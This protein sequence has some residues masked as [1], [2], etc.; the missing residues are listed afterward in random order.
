VVE[1]VLLMSEEDSWVEVKRVNRTVFETAIAFPGSHQVIVEGI[2]RN[3]ERIGK[4][5]NIGSG[6]ACE[7][8]PR[9]WFQNP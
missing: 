3:G 9:F 1:W 4:S 8:K 7:N 2:G 5:G 6:K